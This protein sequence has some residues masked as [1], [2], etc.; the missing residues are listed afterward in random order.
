MYTREVPEYKEMTPEEEKK[1]RAW[2]RA[3]HKAGTS[4]CESWHPIT[5]DE[6]AKMNNEYAA[7]ER[8]KKAELEKKGGK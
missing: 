6:C 3:N 4:T 5:R 2:A 7:K 8:L 1:A